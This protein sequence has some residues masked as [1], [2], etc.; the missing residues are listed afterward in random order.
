LEKPERHALVWHG[1][2]D[3]HEAVGWRE[4]EILTLDKVNT[5]ET[6]LRQ[7]PECLKVDQT[8][9]WS[10]FLFRPASTSEPNPAELHKNRSAFPSVAARTPAA[11]AASS[12]TQTGEIVWR[13]SLNQT[14]SKL[15]IGK[16]GL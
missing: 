5:L 4:L 2:C 6:L 10:V 13:R 14:Q 7:N 3:T 9:I 11:P 16:C 1:P 15:E 12:S 8:W